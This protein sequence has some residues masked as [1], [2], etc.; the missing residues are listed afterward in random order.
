MKE[1][2]STTDKPSSQSDARHIAMTL[3]TEVPF[4]VTRDEGVLGAGDALEEAFG[5]HVVAP[6]EIVR[7][8][9]ELRC[10]DNYRPRR[11]FFGPGATA[12]AARASEVTE[13]VDLTYAG[14]VAAEPRRRTEGRLRE[15]L[16]APERYEAICIRYNGTLVAAYVLD[17][18]VPRR[19]S[20]PFF[21]VAPS[22]IGRTAARHYGESFIV[23]ASREGRN[24]VQVEQPDQRVAQ[25]LDDL[26]FSDEVGIWVKLTL[27]MTLSADGA[28][29]QVEHVAASGPPAQQL[30][31]RLASELRAFAERPALARARAVQVERALWPAKIVAAGVPCF[32][33]PIQ[34]RWAKDLFDRELAAETLF[35]ANPSLVLNSENVYYRA[36]RPEVITAPSRVVWYVSDDPAFPQSKALRACSYIDEVVVDRPK[37]LYRRFKRL[38]VYEWEDVYAIA[39]H[40]VNREIMAFRFS[41]TEMFTGPVTWGAMQEIFRKYRGKQQTL[42]SPLAI[43]EG[44]FFDIYSRGMRADAA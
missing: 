16:A 23:T 28:A 30:A 25:A 15:L 31:L 17:R 13:I 20:V 44:C 8:F 10:E 37:E 33:I 6:H 18:D 1:L 39:K 36:A 42:Q 24:I 19:L 21:A 14:Q 11:L 22:S 27:P 26:G 32:V 41:K 7:R 9:D 40:D 43:S 5:L 35:G 2:L 12:S 34:P 3:A 4:F 29:E 38:G